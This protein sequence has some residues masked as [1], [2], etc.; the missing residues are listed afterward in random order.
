MTNKSQTFYITKSFLGCI[1]IVLACKTESFIIKMDDGSSSFDIPE[2][3]STASAYFAATAVL[4]FRRFCSKDVKGA[5][6]E[7]GKN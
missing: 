2:K 1:A 6:S 4:I 5:T 3:L 7:M